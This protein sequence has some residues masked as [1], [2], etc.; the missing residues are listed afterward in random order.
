M[1]R[2]RFRF[3][4]R[5]RVRSRIWYIFRIRLLELV[6]FQVPLLCQR[7]ATQG[8]HPRLDGSLGPL[9]QLGGSKEPLSRLDGSQG[10]LIRLKKKLQKYQNQ[11]I[12]F[13][14]SKL[15]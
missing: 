3:R 8:P 9:L 10:P 15:F 7:S 4:I 2:I 5:I 11:K 1:H 6:G 13:Q 12:N 14:S